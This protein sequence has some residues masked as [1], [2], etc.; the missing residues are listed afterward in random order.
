M[1]TPST[2]RALT[3]HVGS[4]GLFTGLD[5]VI[6]E[7]TELPEVEGPIPEAGAD[8]RH[9]AQSATQTG[10][11]KLPSG[12][13][14]SSEAAASPTA[15]ANAAGA[16]KADG[17]RP[18]HTGFKV[19][20]AR[21]PNSADRLN[22]AI[23]SSAAAES[24]AHSPASPASRDPHSPAEMAVRCILPNEVG[25]VH[26]LVGL[27]TANLDQA[28]VL[29]TMPAVSQ[30]A[31]QINLAD[32]VQLES[33]LRAAQVQASGAEDLGT[34]KLGSG[35]SADLGAA[36][37]SQ[38]STAAISMSTT[39]T[40]DAVASRY[41]VF[42]SAPSFSQQLAEAASSSLFASGLDKHSLQEQVTMIQQRV[43]MEQLR[44]TEGANNVPSTFLA[45]QCV[46]MI[47]ECVAAVQATLKDEQRAKQRQRQL[48]ASYSK[49]EGKDPASIVVARYAAGIDLQHMLGALHHLAGIDNHC[50]TSC[51]FHYLAACS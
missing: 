10:L 38:L 26:E 2:V 16:S 1:Q 35:S 46:L 32:A 40:A 6:E 24:A 7:P 48:L 47:N 30:P 15:A 49:A 39:S 43:G 13:A 3:R 37:M 12:P 51:A 29:T 31:A 34:L 19:G 20:Y 42:D 44:L 18:R 41:N 9:N 50:S 28:P 33:N 4:A 5:L 21:A 25:T 8:G 45:I 17:K 23:A 22:S 14:P 36:G 27:E 11:H